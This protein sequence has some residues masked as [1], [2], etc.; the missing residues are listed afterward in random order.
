MRQSYVTICPSKAELRQQL[1][2][3]PVCSNTKYM[4]IDRTMFPMRKYLLRWKAGLEINY[5]MCVQN[6][7]IKLWRTL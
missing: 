1:L 6:T 7:H 5:L 2:G 4:F 3:F